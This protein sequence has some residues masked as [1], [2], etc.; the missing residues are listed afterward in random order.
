MSEIQRNPVVAIN[1]SFPPH[2]S[3]YI[4]DNKDYLYYI[5]YRTQYLQDQYT[6]RQSQLAPRGPPGTSGVPGRDGSDGRPGMDGPTGLP[7]RDGPPGK[8]GYPG[9][10]GA[11]GPPGVNGLPGHRG[12]RGFKGERGEAGLKGTLISIYVSYYISGQVQSEEN[13]EK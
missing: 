7:G 11:P 8:D 5:S 1:T 9:S 3:R 12:E 4:S 13:M 2:V 6:K 10:A